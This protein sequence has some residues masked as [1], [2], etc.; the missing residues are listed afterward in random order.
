[1]IFDRTQTQQVLDQA[2]AKAVQATKDY[3]NDWQLM[4]GGN[5]YSEPFYCGFAWVDAKVRSNS[6]LGKLLKEF[7]FKKHWSRAGVMQLWNPSNYSGQSM[8]VKEAGAMAYAEHL[9]ANGINCS[10]GCR[11]D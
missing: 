11:A 4:T 8:D 1:M 9:N 6:K 3:L 5:E 10:W 2:K 7:G